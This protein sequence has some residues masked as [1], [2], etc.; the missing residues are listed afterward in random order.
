MGR[1]DS[2]R[3]RVVPVFDALHQRDPT[4]ATWLNTLTSFGTRSQSPQRP[5]ECGTLLRDHPRYWGK[6]ERRLAPPI[7]LLRWLVGNASKP[8]SESLWGSAEAKKKREELVDGKEPTIKEALK[9]LDGP[10]RRRAWYILEG[11]SC[12][13]AFLETDKVVLVIEGKRTERKLTTTTTWM[14]KRSQI[15]RHMDAAYEIRGA[16]KVLGL[17][18]VEGEGGSEAVTPTQYWLDQADEQVAPRV[19]AGSL[20][21]RS[22]RLHSEIA[23][24]FLGVATWQRVCCE[25]AIQWPPCT[26]AA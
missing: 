15:I 19:L 5:S 7:T 3:T 11:E 2:S 24:G 8:S 16:R 13:D 23:G 21:R 18:I 9:L 12:P 6:N 17:T 20:P 25:L 10:R 14:A 26:D 22:P 1:F 4:G